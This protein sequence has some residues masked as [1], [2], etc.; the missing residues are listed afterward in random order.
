MVAAQVEEATGFTRNVESGCAD[1]LS[2]CP[3]PGDGSSRVEGQSGSNPA[4]GRSASRET[5]T[6]S[7]MAK[8]SFRV[9]T[10]H[11][12]K[13]AVDV[14]QATRRSVTCHL[15]A[16]PTTTHVPPGEQPDSSPVPRGRVSPNVEAISNK[17]LVPHETIAKSEE[18]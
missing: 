14:L 7:R 13:E 16:H 9:L 17:L 6:T 1:K 5:A 8:P 15:P 11:R 3:L 12:G 18:A 2:P 4:D 10:V